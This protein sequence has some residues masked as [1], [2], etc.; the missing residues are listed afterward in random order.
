MNGEYTMF[1]VHKDKNNNKILLAQTEQLTLQSGA[2][3]LLVA[4]PDY[5][6]DSGYKLS[7]VK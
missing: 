3:Y 6:A 5:Y 2:N 1:I 4:E 7:L